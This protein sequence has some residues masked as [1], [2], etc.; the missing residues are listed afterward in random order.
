TALDPSFA[1]G[2]AVVIESHVTAL[3]EAAAVVFELHP[4]LMLARRDGLLGHGE[5]IVDAE[6]IVAIFELAF[7]AVEG[8]AAGLATLRD[9]HALGAAF[10][11]RDLARDRVR[12]V[13]ERQDAGL[14]HTHAGK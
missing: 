11:N 12:L 9:D 14:A 10:G 6:E 8:P 13:F 7:V 4:H 1:H 3:G 5:E 2:F